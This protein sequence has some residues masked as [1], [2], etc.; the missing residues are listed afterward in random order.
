MKTLITI[1][2]A[3]LIAGSSYAQVLDPMGGDGGAGNSGSSDNSGSTKT[4]KDKSTPSGLTYNRG[5]Y[6]I[7]STLNLQDVA[8]LMG[9]MKTFKVDG[10]G[11]VTSTF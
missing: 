3:L 6:G 7:N 8:A 1:L 11:N 5:C 9:S 2:L 4:K 10:T